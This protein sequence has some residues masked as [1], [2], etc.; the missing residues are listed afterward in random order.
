M[1]KTTTPFSM[2]STAGGSGMT[3]TPTALGRAVSQP[4][5]AIACPVQPRVPERVIIDIGPASHG[6]RHLLHAD[7]T[8]ADMAIIAKSAF[9]VLDDVL[10]EAL[11]NQATDLL[12][13]FRAQG[14]SQ[15]RWM[16]NGHFIETALPPMVVQGNTVDMNTVATQ[17]QAWG[18]AM[19]SDAVVGTVQHDVDGRPLTFDYQALYCYPDG[20]DLMLRRKPDGSVR[21][22]AADGPG[23]RQ[24]PAG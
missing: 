9:F 10:R 1:K 23:D 8:A 16:R 17:L 4:S 2:P 3:V 21:D 20:V 15:V 13:Q 14:A 19:P 22:V 5:V 18:L 7:L 11:S 24:A 6:V 12:W